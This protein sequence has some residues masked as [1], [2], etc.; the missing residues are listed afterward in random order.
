[1][2]T[3]KY[4]LTIYVVIIVIGLLAACSGS[5]PSPEST[6]QLF[7]K[8]ISGTWDT[9]IVTYDGVDVTKSFQSMVLTINENKSISVTNPVSPIW[10]V[11]GTFVLIPSGTNFK[12]KRNDGLLI[13]IESTTSQKLVLTFLFDASLL[14]SRASS[15]VGNFKFEL[16]K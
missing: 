10:K 6:E 4:T 1:M 12:L 13:N 8:K 15:V 2:N 5:D 14:T 9:S 3:R 7:L 16:T 11:A